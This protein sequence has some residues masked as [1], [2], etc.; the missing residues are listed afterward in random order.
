MHLQLACACT[1][2][3]HVDAACRPGASPTSSPAAHPRAPPSPQYSEEDINFDGKPDIITFSASVQ[4]KVPIH[5]V[6][7]LLQFHY[8]FSVGGHSAFLFRTFYYFSVAI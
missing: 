5:G 2:A 7:A 8:S 3:A 6:Q 4:S 1:T